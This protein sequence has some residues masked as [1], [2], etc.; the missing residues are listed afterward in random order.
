MKCSSKG[1]DGVMCT[2]ECDSLS[3]LNVHAVIRCSD[4]R[5]VYMQKGRIAWKN[6]ML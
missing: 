4:R 3:I 1:N 5:N 6:V 2:R